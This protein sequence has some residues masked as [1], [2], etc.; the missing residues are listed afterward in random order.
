MQVRTHP[1]IA[2]ENKLRTNRLVTALCGCFAVLLLLPMT[3]WGASANEKLSPPTLETLYAAPAYQSPVLSPDGSK[4]AILKRIDGRMA[5]VVLDLDHKSVKIASASKEWDIVDPYWINNNRL[6][7]SISDTKV[8]W[9][10]N[11]GGGLFAVNADGTGF[12]RLG[13]T[14]QQA[15][16]ENAIYRPMTLLRRVGDGSNDILVEYNERNSDDGFGG[17]DVYLLDTTNGRKKLLSFVSPG[18]V[19]GWIVDGNNQV[20]VA[21]SFDNDD[22]AKQVRTTVYYREHNDAKWRVMTSY[23][24]GEAG[25][26]PLRFDADNQTLYVTGRTDEDKNAIYKWDFEHGKPGELLIAH[27][28]A[29]VEGGL[30]TDQQGKVIAVLVNALMPE[31]Y[32]FDE[33][34]ANLQAQIDAVLPG[35]INYI[36]VAGKRAIV[37]SQA[38]TDM[39]RVYFMD[40]EKLRLEQLFDSSPDI[41]PDAMGH[42]RAY[43]YKARDGLDIPAYLTLPPGGAKKLPLVAY[44]HGGPDVRDTWG[45]DPIVQQLATAGYAV[46]QPQFRM[47]TG[48]GW[49]LFR[50]G[51]K[52]WGLTMQ[53]DITDGIQQL[54]DDGIVDPARI[55]IMGASYGG[56]AAMYGVAKTPDLYKCAVNFVGVTDISLLYSVT[57]GDTAGSAFAKYSLKDMHGDPDKDQDYMRKAS[58][59]ENADKIKAPVLM[60]YGSDDIRVPLIHGQRIRDLLQ[61]KGNTVEWKVYAGE[62]HGWSKLENR[63]DWAARFQSFIDRYI[64]DCADSSKSGN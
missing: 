2:K 59:L 58:V 27:P 56:Y 37:Y 48:F 40:V 64:G 43:A 26:S 53:D 8:V 36:Q 45:Y 34:R 47:S 49:K 5:L 55:C 29:D 31:M 15:I 30:I 22:A 33:E 25:F 12:R 20:R 46:F 52:Q 35:R 1:R 13:M 17:T 38:E 3:L 60:A 42:A 6:V 57:W 23:L 14:V 24:Y 44:I 9:S 63:L 11:H 4:L 19:Q 7:F 41:H 21:V 61:K 50:S 32:Y 28:Q 39:G 10:E 18:H 62:G 51:W 16:A 54:V